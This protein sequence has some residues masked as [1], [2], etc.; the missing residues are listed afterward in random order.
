MN[1]KA[2]RIALLLSACALPLSLTAPAAAQQREAADPSAIPPDIRPTTQAEDDQLN[3]LSGLIQS[4]TAEKRWADAIAVANQARAIE[5]KTKGPEHPEVAGT[6]GLTAGWLARLDRFTEAEPLLRRSLAIFRKRLGDGHPL[7]ASATN[8]LAANLA[9]QGKYE[10]AQALYLQSL[11][12]CRKFYGEQHRRTAACYGNVGSALTRQGRYLEAATYLERALAIANGVMKEGE[13]ELALYE[14]NFAANLNAQGRYLEAAP[15]YDRALR[16]RLAVLGPNDA[17]TATSYNN[18]AFNLNAQGRYEEAAPL[19]VKAMEIRAKIAPDDLRAAT[20]YNNVAHNLNRRGRHKEAAPLY[21]KALEIWKA[22]LGGDHPTTAIGYSNVAANLEAMGRYVEAQPLFEKAL[23][24]RQGK[25]NPAHPDVATGTIKLAHVLEMQSR[26]A[27]ADALYAKGVAARRGGLDPLHPDLAKGISDYAGL[28]TSLGPAGRAKAVPLAR[29]AVSIVRQRR[30]ARLSGEAAG[31]GAGAAQQA[32]TR[33]VGGDATQ[34]D[35]L[36]GA[37]ATFLRAAWL[38]GVDAPTEATSLRDESFAAAQDLETSAAAQTMAQTAARAAAGTSELARLVRRQQDLS[39][40]ARELD[41]RLFVA[42]SKG[43]TREADKTRQQMIRAA[44]DLAAADKQLRTGF[45]DYAELVQPRAL[46]VAETQSRLRPGEGLILIVPAKDDVF[47]FGLAPGKIAWN[48]LAGGAGGAIDRVTKLRCQADPLTCGDKATDALLDSGA[49]PNSSFLGDGYA[50]F[51]RAASYQLYRDLVQPVES[52][53]ADAKRLYVTVS[54]TLS[55]LPLGALMTE[56]PKSGEDGANPDTLARSAW[57]ADRYALTSLPSVSVLRALRPKGVGQGNGNFIGY[58][59]PVLEG[60]TGK[61][62]RS[63][64]PNAVFVT[65]DPVE[66]VPLANPDLLRTFAPLPGTASELSA[67]AK[68]LKASGQ[69]IKLGPKAT[70]GAVRSDGTLKQAR[71]IA[72]ATHGLLPHEIKGVEEP[73]LVFTPPA[74][75]SSRDDGLLSASEVSRLSLAADW[76]ILSACNTAS[77]DGQPGDDG[78]SSLARSF[79]YAGANALLASHWRVADDATAALTVETLKL[80]EAN[81]ALTRAEALRLAMRSI[82]IGK[83]ED[84]TAVAGWNPTWSHP[85]AWAP[86]TVIS[87]E[88][89]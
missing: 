2:L 11:E 66:G 13:A 23:A 57:L 69:Q 76:V 51:D 59:N 44:S 63:I 64:D 5:E 83:R 19:Y 82:R 70:E 35:P 31:Q 89:R 39:V 33:A 28:L 32:L 22:K 52:A 47:S 72:F 30:E 29:E 86:F 88:D 50:A 43:D 46:S 20:S 27:A 61:A 49:A 41:A 14:T 3:R 17:D 73:G 40:K 18:V 67:M 77:A 12:V 45:P 34:V 8:N 84:G 16:I 10:E 78:L 54:G 60:P 65:V 1:N 85:A 24:V 7:T 74:Q 25:L 38:R 4:A 81:S 42:L 26:F 56:P 80:R 6:L 79:L 21:Q 75:P 58:G 87:N 53:F 15:H 55:G 36:A 48:R 9:E 71:I 37:F 68:A 62:A